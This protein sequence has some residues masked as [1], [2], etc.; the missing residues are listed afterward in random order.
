MKIIEKYKDVEFNDT[1]LLRNKSIHEV[2]TEN[3]WV[4]YMANVLET[5]EPEPVNISSNVTDEERRAVKELAVNKNIVIKRADKTNIFVVMDSEF[6]RNKLVLN[7]HLSSSTYERAADDADVKVFKQQ[8][9]LLEKHRNCLTK[10]E[11]NYI[12]DYEWKSSLFYVNPKIAK[13]KEISERM[14]TNNSEYLHM[15]PPP[16]LK[17]RPIISGP[18]SPI[19]HLSQLISKILAPLVPLQQS[20]IKDA[21]AFIKRL[22]K[23]LSYD[24]E[25]FTCDIVSLYTSIPHSLGIEAMD[26]WIQNHREVIPD[27]FTRNFIIE[28]I[29]FILENNN[30]IFEGTYYHQTEGTGM[31]IDFAGNYAC[32]SIGYLEEVKLFGPTM[33]SYFNAEDIALIRIAFLR[34]VDDGFM[35]WPSHLDIEVFISLLRGCNPSIQYT[36]EKGV[37]VH[38][39]R[40]HKNFLEVLV[41]LHNGRLI[42]TELYYKPTNNHHYLE[43][44]SP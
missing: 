9:K 29:L 35:F 18:A 10:N 16:S 20:Y 1:S 19:K 42:E 31:G 22:P 23:Q 44:E 39:N 17:G 3:E 11:F 41:I 5:L 27:R 26:Y 33:L 25:L 4:Q 15:E 14:R 40:Q 21:W 43:Y 13:C 37:V 38:S 12:T 8:T 36:V 7:D 28:A 6:Y 34:Y 2:K 32:L 24:A 30:F